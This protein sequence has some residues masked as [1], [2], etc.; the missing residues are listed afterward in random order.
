VAYVLPTIEAFK[1]QFVR[2]FPF[3]TPLNPAGVTAN[4]AVTAAISNAGSVTGLTVTTAGAGYSSPLPT[5][6]IYGGGGLG[7]TGSVTVTGGAI[8][9]A[10]VVNPGYGYM[11]APYVYVAVGDNTDTEKVTDYDIARGLQVGQI[12]LNSGL[13]SNQASFTYAYNLLG[14][15]YLCESVI[16]G[17]TGLNG[18]A[19]WLV[20][21]RQVGNVHEQFDIPQ[22]ILNSPFL[23]KLSKTTYGAQFLELVS[24][25]LIANMLPFHRCALP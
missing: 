16:A 8:T 14:A 5:L 17:T 13:W 15:H 3:A 18:K 22:R 11:T 7:A 21:A 24:P 4:A 6:V 12:N 25:Q 23:S 20:K 19:D 2:D 9:A 10:A 1:A